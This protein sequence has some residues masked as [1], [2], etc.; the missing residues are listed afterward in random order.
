MAMASKP[1]KG[2]GSDD[3]TVEPAEIARKTA[4]A[5]VE[6]PFEMQEALVRLDPARQ[7][8]L[9]ALAAGSTMRETCRVSGLGMAAVKTLRDR[10]LPAIRQGQAALEW[11]PGSDTVKDAAANWAAQSGAAHAQLTALVLDRVQ[12]DGA[13]L[14]TKELAELTTTL[15]ALT[16]SCAELL[17]ITGGLG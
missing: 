10:F 15:T 16:R 7:A 11:K 9:K 3:V 8:A 14:T 13:T 12:R 4:I 1:S 2:K 17:R 6:S 5:P